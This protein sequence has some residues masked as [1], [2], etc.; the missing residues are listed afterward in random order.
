MKDAAESHTYMVAYT[1]AYFF[2][3]MSI[4]C[5]CVASAEALLHECCTYRSFTVLAQVV[6]REILCGFVCTCMPPLC[7]GVFYS[8]DQY[9]VD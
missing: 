6:S 8:A 2:A 3:Q 1:Q 9:A 4:V 7:M 5:L